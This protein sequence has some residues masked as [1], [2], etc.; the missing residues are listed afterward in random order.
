VL[1]FW[2]F[3]VGWAAAKSTSVWQRLVV[4]VVLV[5]GIAGYFGQPNREVLVFVGLALLI[6]FPAIRCPSALTVVAGLVAEA[7][8]FV[9]LTHYQVYP[10]FGDHVLVGVIAS[11]IVG[12]LLTQLVNRLRRVIRVRRAR[13]LRSVAAP[14]L[15]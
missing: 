8:L 9:Y 7:S 14:A 11:V 15:R 5:A 1:A 4:T 12:V 6:W 13:P 10:L 3:A 2:F